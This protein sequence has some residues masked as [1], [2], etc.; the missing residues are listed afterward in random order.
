MKS[1]SG[2]TVSPWMEGTSPPPEE[3]LPTAAP[4]DVCVIGGG[5][6]GMSVAYLL[7]RDGRSVALIDDGPV[8]GGETCRTS[9]HLSS[10]IDDGFVRIEKLHGT[11]GAR[12]A[13]ASHAAAIDQIE[14][15]V[16]GERIDCDFQRVDGFLFQAPG[17]SAEELAEEYAAAERA[18]AKVEAFPRSPVEGLALGPCLRFADQAQMHPMRYLRGLAEAFVRRGGHI[19]TGVHVVAVHDGEP[20]R[21]ELEDG[22]TL[23]AG[24]VVVATNS[25]FTTLFAMHT[26]QAPYRTFVIAAE[27]APGGIPQ[28]L[29]WDTEDPYH[30]VRVDPARGPGELD[31]LLVGGEDHKTGQADDADA[32]FQRLE[33][34]M[35]AHFPQA[36]A[37]RYRWS[38][39]VLET[40]DGLAYIGREPGARHIYLSTGDSGMGL[41]HGTIA[42]ML[43]TDLIQGRENPWT[44]LY[45]PDRKPVRAAE[46]YLRENLNVAAQ[47]ADHVK[48]GQAAHDSEIANG[49]GAVLRRGVHL[50]AAYR[51]H[52]GE[53]HEHSAVC[54]H[55]GCIVHFNSTEVTWDCPCHGS[56]FDMEGRVV[57]GPA[58]R[59]L[60]EI[61]YDHVQGAPVTTEFTT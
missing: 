54:S 50:V 21:I 32:R 22:R 3:S 9:A 57:N 23:I 43:L 29:M 51:D 33:Q 45:A 20:A 60:A 34:W 42:G 39:Q 6:A 40:L 18:G 49:T 38:G 31:L 8:G 14:S 58:S 47:Y 30:Y 12:L 59:P 16:R 1:D 4:A 41:T 13:H 48:P 61:E 26:Q 19:H 36:D 46:E 24:T 53:L 28:R 27:C 10:A 44:D 25:P 11:E 2:K 55:L 56:R 15:I 5:I 7:A 35:R 17:T 52:S 37:V